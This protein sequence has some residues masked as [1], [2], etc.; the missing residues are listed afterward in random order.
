MSGIV[1]VAVDDTIE[2]WITSNSATSR[3]VTGEDVA[4]SLTMVGG[5]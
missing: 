2:F 5:T 4:L 1:D 3:N